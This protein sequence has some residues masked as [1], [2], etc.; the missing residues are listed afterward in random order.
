M[1]RNIYVMNN[2][3]VV[4]YNNAKSMLLKHLLNTF[5]YLFWLWSTF[6]F[7]NDQSIISGKF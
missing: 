2:V 1:K 5:L 7:Q 3:K 4:L 6:I